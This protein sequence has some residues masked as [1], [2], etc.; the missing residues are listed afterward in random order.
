MSVEMSEVLLSI[1]DS[2]LRH[3]PE[4]AAAL[5][6]SAA[7]LQQSCLLVLLA[8]SAQ[9]QTKAS[10]FALSEAF[11]DEGPTGMPG[12]QQH[13]L[14]HVLI[15]KLDDLLLTGYELKQV[16]LIWCSCESTLLA[17]RPAMG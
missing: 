2:L 9:P 10:L 16:T 15:V 8:L 13:Q 3:A 17:Y 1:N 14:G 4:D 5:D 12:A 6:D 7:E 11:L